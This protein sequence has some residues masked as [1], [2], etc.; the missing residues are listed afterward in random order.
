MQKEVCRGSGV[1]AVPVLWVLLY[2]GEVMLQ[3]AM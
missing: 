1:A 2:S 3:T